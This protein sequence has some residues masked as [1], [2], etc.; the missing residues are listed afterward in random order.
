VYFWGCNPGSVLINP[1]YYTMIGG[2][3]LA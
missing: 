1:I 3:F 2:P